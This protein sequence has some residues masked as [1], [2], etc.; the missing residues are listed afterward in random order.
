MEV[1]NEDN[2]DVLDKTGI[3]KHEARDICESLNTKPIDDNIGKAY[4]SD[5]QFSFPDEVLRSINLDFIKFNLRVEDESK[6]TEGAA[7]TTVN[8][9]AKD[10][11]K[12]KECDAEKIINPSE[13]NVDKSNLDQRNQ[14][15]VHIHEA[16]TE[17]RK[18]E[19]NLPDSQVTIPDEL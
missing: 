10:E 2:D 14:T 7:E 4:I 6:N 17:E 3:D 19:Q 1:Y 9:S 16:V 13:H 8:T 11:S 15:P 5:S 18:S 12:D